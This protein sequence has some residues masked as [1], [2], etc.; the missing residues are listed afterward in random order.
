MDSTSKII[1]SAME[2]A[3]LDAVLEIEKASFAK[4]WKIEHFLQEIASPH[5]FPA[6]ALEEGRVVGFICLMSLFEEAQILDVAVDTGQRGKGI[7]QILIEFAEDLA[8]KKGAE[9]LALEVRESNVPARCLYEKN[10]YT[11]NGIRTRY[12]DGTENAILMI[13]KIC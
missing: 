9:S 6:V 12:Y 2:H 13:K 3:H 4:P 1:V 5:S 10:G 7:A 11:L 8:A